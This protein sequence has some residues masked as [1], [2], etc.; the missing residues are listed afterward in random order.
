MNIR[1]FLNHPR[2]IFLPGCAD[3]SAKVQFINTSD[4]MLHARKL[5]ESF[6]L[7]CAEFSVCN[8]PVF[9]YARSSERNHLMVLGSKAQLYSGPRSLYGMIKSFDRQKAA[10]GD[11]DAYSKLF[12]PD[13]VMTK[14]D[15]ELIQPAL[16]GRG[17]DGLHLAM[18]DRIA[19]RGYRLFDRA[20]KWTRRVS[21]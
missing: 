2:V 4:A 17:I 5:G 7:A 11:W 6:G 3:L 15:R 19:V 1:P 21:W 18:R 9:T 14:F 10:M 20:L 12:H 8:K 13:V 16:L